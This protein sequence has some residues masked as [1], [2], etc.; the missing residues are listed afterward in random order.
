MRPYSN[1]LLKTF[2]GWN[3]DNNYELRGRIWVIWDPSVSITILSKSIQKVTCLVKLPS[4]ECAEEMIVSFV[5]ALNTREERK[6]AELEGMVGEKL[7]VSH[8][9]VVIVGQGGWCRR[10]PCLLG[11]V[12]G[13]RLRYPCSCGIEYLSSYPLSEIGI[14]KGSAVV[15]IIPLLRL[16][17]M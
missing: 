14:M 1:F 15:R 4:E 12:N 11:R 13:L 16:P 3:H 6:R 9:L 17:C 8:S 7:M 10:Q 5:Y 2:P